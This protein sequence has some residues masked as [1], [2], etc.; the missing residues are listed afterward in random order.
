[1]REFIINSNDGGQRLDKYVSKT[2]RGLPPSLMYKFIRKKKIKVNGKRAE[3]KQILNAEDTVQ[4]YIPEEFFEDKKSDANTEE[5]SRIKVRLNIVY[6]DENIILCDKKPGLLSHTGDESENHSD[7]SSERETLIYQIKAYLY[8][9]GE[10]N[11]EA[12]NSFAPALCNRIDRN[13][14]GIVIAA[15][16]APALR[17]MNEMIKEGG[18]DKKYLCAAHGKFAQKTDVLRGFL[19]KNSKTK[20][21]KVLKEKIQGSK[22]IIT[23]YKALD[24]D[25]SHDLTLLEVTLHTGRTHQI[26]AHMASIGHPL[27]GEGK[28]AQNKTDRN[29]GWTH[30]ALYSYKIA[31]DVKEGELAYLDKKEFTVNLENV[32]FLRFFPKYT[33]N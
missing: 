9:H 12:E 30:Q 32:R 2:L 8:Q 18:V 15:K 5:M 25:K 24:Y 26:R 16:N 1:M 3:E 22:E 10:Y 19:F 11:P 27:L 14:G 23:E 33:V 21:V 17:A 7:E 6:E 29:L 28:Y 13:T 4:M 20:T 31:F